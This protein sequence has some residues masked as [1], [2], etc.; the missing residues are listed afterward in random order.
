MVALTLIYLVANLLF[1]PLGIPSFLSGFAFAWKWGF[2]KGMFLCVFWNFMFWHF[3]HF[4]AFLLGRY[5]LYDFIYS[6]WERYKLFYVLNY[7]I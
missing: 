3:A 6:R 1:I 5:M 2:W 4:C 7:A